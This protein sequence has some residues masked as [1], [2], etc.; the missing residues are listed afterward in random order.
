MRHTTLTAVSHR[1]RPRARGKRLF[2]VACLSLFT[3]F[4]VSAATACLITSTPQF[5]FPTISAPILIAEEPDPRNLIVFDT[6]RQLTSTIPIVAHVQSE[7]FDQDHQ[8]GEPLET[9]ILFDYGVPNGAQPFALLEPEENITPAHLADGNRFIDISW[10]PPESLYGCHTITLVVSHELVNG[11]PVDP[12]DAAQVTWFLKLCDSTLPGPQ[13]DCSDI[14]FSNGSI[15]IDDA[16][17]QLSTCPNQ[18]AS[19][20][21]FADAGADGGAP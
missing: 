6:A 7:D 19:C 1:A 4:A 5:Q 17:T 15:T 12:A 2:R 14:G 21:S 9:E 10:V 18:L 11:C 3:A 20:A 8:D 16:G 13:G